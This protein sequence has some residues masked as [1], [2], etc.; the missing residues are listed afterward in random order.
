VVGSGET[1]LLLTGVAGAPGIALGAVYPVDRQRIRVPQHRLPPGALEHEV[2]RLS[3]ALALSRHQLSLAK[4]KLHVADHAQI[5][6]AHL[7]LFHDPEL[8]QRIRQRIIEAG[9]NAEWAVEQVIAETARLFDRIDDIYLKERRRDFE[10]VQRRLLVNLMGIQQE[11]L[12]QIEQPVVLVTHD[13]SPADLANLDRAKVL[14]ILVDVGT[15]TGHTAI[16][17]RALEIPT[18]VGL[19]VITAEAKTGDVAIVDGFEGRVILNPSPEQIADFEARRQIHEQFEENLQSFRDRPAQTADGVQLWLA[20]NIGLPNEVDTVQKNGLTRIGLFRTEF[21]FLFSHHPPSED[22]QYA[23][24]RSVVERLGP[25]GLTTIRTIDLGGDKAL[26]ASAEMQNEANPAMGLRAIRL[27]LAHPDIFLTQLRAILRAS[28]HGRLRILIPMIDGVDE[29]RKVKEYLVAAQDELRAQGAA[30]DPDV[31]IGVM[32]ETPAAVMLADLLAPEVDFFSIGTNDLI[33]YTLAVDRGN[34]HLNYLFHPLHPAVLRGIRHVVEAGEAAGIP[35][36]MCGEMAGQVEYVMII[37]GLGVKEL[38][39]A[40]RKA[41]QVKRVLS[42]FS[43]DEARTQA[44]A[45][46]Q[47]K[48]TQEVNDHVLTV[49]HRAFPEEFDLDRISPKF[50]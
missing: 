29:L 27:C 15:A 16:L 20:A 26:F 17:A 39:M 11:S 31:E 38:S 28:A 32:I 45:A 48:T 9:I 7:S 34:E 22:E 24:Y 12:E 35:V 41:L 18:V 33:Q 4:E 5:L 40:P 10:Y 13:L 8:I 50:E 2:E 6:D 3:S 19:E 47:F 37:V 1:T 25:S 43:L 14:A 30:F 49:M 36:A 46:L 42:R 44:A 21:L 23:V